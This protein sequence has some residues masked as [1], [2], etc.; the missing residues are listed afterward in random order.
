MSRF[1]TAGWISASNHA[2]LLRAD[3]LRDT[4]DVGWF[5]SLAPPRRYTGDWLA[6]GGV[7]R[8]G[9]RPTAP[10]WATGI[11]GSCG[12]RG[13]PFFSAAV[14]RHDQAAH[15]LRGHRP[16]VC[17][18]NQCRLSLTVPNRPERT[19]P[20]AVRAIVR[21]ARAPLRTL[22]T[23]RPQPYLNPAFDRFGILNA[24]HDL[25]FEATPSVSA[26][27]ADSCSAIHP[28]ASS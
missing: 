27:M 3:S 18:W 17:R 12:T 14:P 6:S 19:N 2:D 10:A 24:N 15:R 20:Q 23:L 8:P 21:V 9:A 5:L 22:R 28:A 1:T 7:S 16:P 26:L 4:S 13:V 25:V 11:Q